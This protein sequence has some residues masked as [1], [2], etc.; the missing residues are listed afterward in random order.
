[1]LFFCLIS[2]NKTFFGVVQEISYFSALFIKIR[3]IFGVVQEISYFSALFLKIRDIFWWCAG[4][5]SY[6]SALFPKKDIFLVL[7]R[8]S[9]IFLLYLK[10][11]KIFFGVLWRKSIAKTSS[12]LMSCSKGYQ[13]ARQV[14]RCCCYD[15]NNFCTHLA[16]DGQFDRPPGVRCPVH[17]PWSKVC[18]ENAGNGCQENS[19]TVLVVEMDG[20]EVKVGG[21]KCYRNPN[22][23]YFLNTLS[24][25]K[26]YKSLKNN[27]APLKTHFIW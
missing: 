4:S 1:M 27:S 26:N 14:C 19:G 2:K 23:N 5:L 12:V 10:K 18:S 6:F 11:K 8:K 9:V 25:N 7:Y 15:H 17:Q 24:W 20:H 16:E 13:L 3:H 21:H 22:A